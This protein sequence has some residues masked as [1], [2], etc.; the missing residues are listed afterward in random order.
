MITLI[1]MESNSNLLGLIQSLEERI[2]NL[3]E[4]NIEVNNFFY[5]LHKSIQAVDARI[6][7]IANE[8]YNLKNYSLEK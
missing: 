2:K 3:E 5:K 1:N 6:D 8:S 4:E 7:I